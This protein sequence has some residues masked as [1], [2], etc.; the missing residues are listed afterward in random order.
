MLKQSLKAVKLKGF[1][2]AIDLEVNVLMITFTEGNL[3]VQYELRMP[4]TASTIIK[5]GTTN[6]APPPAQLLAGLEATFKAMLPSMMAKL[7][8][9]PQS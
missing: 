2:Q 5:S 4:G 8:E 6:I 7:D 9:T 1:D 3:A